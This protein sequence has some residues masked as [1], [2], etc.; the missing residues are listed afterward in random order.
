LSAKSIAGARVKRVREIFPDTS[1][2]TVSSMFF[3]LRANV[4]RDFHQRRMFALR[5]T[6]ADALVAR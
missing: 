1:E 2:V 5:A 4:R 6:Q 3:A